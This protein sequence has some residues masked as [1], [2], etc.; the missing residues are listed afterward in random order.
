MKRIF[1]ASIAFTVAL[2]PAYAGAESKQTCPVTLP[3]DQ[4]LG[5]PFPES[6]R[7]YGSEALAVQLPEYG[8][9]ATT[10][11]GHSIAV[12][13]FW[14]SSGFEPGQE[15]A[16]KV[17]VKALNG[18]AND[19]LISSPTNAHSP[20]LGGWTM[21]TGVDIQSPGCWEIT[22]E[23]LDQVLTFVF[24]SVEPGEYYQIIEDRQ[25]G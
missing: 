5:P 15:T 11:E 24:E 10:Q 14:W 17:T 19:L 21:L 7:W 13:L 2:T 18:G 22:G 3:S 25:Q 16:L 20:S 9:W 8:I 6:D 1:L 4:L 12:K 23:Y